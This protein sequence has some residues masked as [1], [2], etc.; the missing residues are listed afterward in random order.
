MLEAKRLARDTILALS[1]LI[2][3]RERQI[4]GQTLIIN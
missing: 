2:F 4:T 1:E 3:L